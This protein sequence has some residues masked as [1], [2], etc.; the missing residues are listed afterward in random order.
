M[1]V[2]WCIERQTIK[3]ARLHLHFRN[4]VLYPFNCLSNELTRL[5]L[6]Q[7]G[8]VSLKH[9]ETLVR[10]IELLNDHHNTREKYTHNR[11]RCWCRRA[12]TTMYI[13]CVSV[14]WGHAER[15]K[16]HETMVY[17]SNCRT[18]WT[19]HSWLEITLVSDY[20]FLRDVNGN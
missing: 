11:S 15:L 4:T 18:I 16:S 1:I 8:N 12:A 19:N 6:M 9:S 2:C 3:F 10:S 20:N 7:R 5:D 17:F 14:S 13:A